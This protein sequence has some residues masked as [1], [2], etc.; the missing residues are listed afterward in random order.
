MD[1]TFVVIESS[2]K[3]NFLEHIDSMDPHINFI[4]QETNAD[5]SIPLLD[6]LLMPQPDNS[7][8]TTVCRKPTQM[9]LYLLHD[10]HH[11]LAAKFSVINTL[12]HR[13]KTVC[14]NLQLLKREEEHLKQTL[15][16]ASTL[17]QLR[18]GPTLNT[19]PTGQLKDPITSGSIHLTIMT[20]SLI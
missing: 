8:T 5:W 6:T 12:T 10:S 13:E 3:D 11:E 1:D 19:S 17:S 20:R 16:D 2:K 9:D 15:R 18:T 7:L 4:I 14:S